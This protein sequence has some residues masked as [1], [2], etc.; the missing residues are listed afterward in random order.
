MGVL[1]LYPPR[2]LLK[3]ILAKQPYKVNNLDVDMTF[4]LVV[5]YK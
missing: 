3:K 4:S 2:R 5:V 1:T